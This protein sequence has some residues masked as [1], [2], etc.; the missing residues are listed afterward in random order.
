MKFSRKSSSFRNTL[1]M[2]KFTSLCL[3][4]HFSCYFSCNFLFS[5]FFCIFFF[6]FFASFL[7][8]SFE[9]K[10]RVFDEVCFVLGL[11]IFI[12]HKG[13]FQ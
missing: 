5:Y 7:G 9:K 1:I 4:I 6:F 3:Y 2:N 12:Q 13:S 8:T 10:E 11:Y